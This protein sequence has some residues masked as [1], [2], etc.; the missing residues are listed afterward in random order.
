VRVAECLLVGPFAGW[1]GIADRLAADGWTVLRVE[2][3]AE[4][5]RKLGQSA[6]VIAVVLPATLRD[7]PAD[8]LLLRA[9]GAGT[10][11]D[12]VVLSPGGR[13]EDRAALL[14]EGAEE[15]LD[16]PVD[17][18]RL[19]GKLA[20]L[21]DRRHLIDDL[22]LI[23]RDPRM[24]E[25]LERI[26]RVGPLKVTVLITG[27]SGTGKE[28]LAQAVHRVW[29]RHDRPFVA[30]NV[31]ALP[32]TL[33][34]SELFGHERG[35]F[36]GADSRRMGRFEMADGGTLFL[37]EI[38][39]MSMASQVN[40]LR[41]LE[42][43]QFLRVGGSQPVSV[44]VRVVAATNRDLEEM[45]RTGLFRRDLY[46]R[47]NVVH[48][49]VPP[50]RERRS[51]IPVLARELAARAARRHGLSFPGFTKDALDALVEYEWPGNVR[52]LRN[53][54][55]GLLALRPETQIRA[56]DLPTQV[57]H[58]HT[59]PADRPLPALPPDRTEAEREFVIQSLLALRAEVAAIR[60]MLRGGGGPHA[61]E[62]Y[63]RPPGGAPVY[64]VSPVRV[65]EAGGRSLKELERSAIAKALREHGGN[66][67]LAAEALGLSERTLYRRIRQFGLAEDD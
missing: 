64:P 33:L 31:G 26:L 52:E 24:L 18:D 32:D 13:P 54:V 9:K 25:L 11:A 1:D 65:E 38:G 50:L 40:L 29:G 27:E 12:F 21:R 2:S 61:V 56:V 5:F 8:N 7:G 15:V 23:V 45:V 14:A 17:P 58:G 41:V 36:T 22:D 46:Y 57:L 43:E 67:R 62:D 44:D 63:G 3:A 6:G 10:R 47:L 4:A 48:I 49:L 28:V 16:E 66:R 35:A 39:E 20:L 34:E 59:A 53:L 51:E 19:V 42:E 55:D 37:D 60:E 30:V